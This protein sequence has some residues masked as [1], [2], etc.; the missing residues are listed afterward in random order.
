MNINSS[1]SSSCITWRWTNFWI[2]FLESSKGDSSPGA[3]LDMENP[4]SMHNTNAVCRQQTPHVNEMEGLRV[5][6]PLVN[7]CIRKEKKKKKDA[8]CRISCFWSQIK[9][10]SPNN[11]KIKFEKY[12]G[13][14][15]W[16]LPSY[17]PRQL[18][19]FLCY[20]SGKK[21]GMTSVPPSLDWLADLSFYLFIYIRW[22][23]FV[24]IRYLTWRQ[25]IIYLLMLDSMNVCWDFICMSTNKKTKF[26]CRSAVLRLY[27]LHS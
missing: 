21:Q 13:V 4:T 6:T 11:K 19:V 22:I 8:F 23:F 10:Q 15:L 2:I 16:L 9:M 7:K 26:K 14:L 27:C 3:A 20:G 17:V 24:L 1:S 18:R 12:L 25:W 5:Y